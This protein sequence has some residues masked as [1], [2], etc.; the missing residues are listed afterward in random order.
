MSRRATWCVGG[1]VNG[2]FILKA[3]PDNGGSLL[4]YRCSCGEV[5]TTHSSN[6]KTQRG[7]RFCWSTRRVKHGYGSNRSKEY[8]AWNAII[9]RCTNPNKPEY[10]HYGRR[11]IGIDPKWRHNFK[12]F[13]ADVGLAPSASVEI[14]RIDNDLGY[15]PGNVRWTTRRVQTRNTRVNRW[16]SLDGRQQVVSD[17]AVE[18]GISA[19]TIRRR[20]NSGWTVRRALTERPLNVGMRARSMKM[21][22]P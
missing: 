2:K 14:D 19:A 22:A 9:Q 5:S 11:G 16:L 12:Q 21:E 10:K 7:C 8:N 1:T 6:I 15:V 17:W 20:L 13:L 4:T 3:V 18:T